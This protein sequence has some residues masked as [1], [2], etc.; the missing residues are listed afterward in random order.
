MET[1]LVC[2]LTANVLLGRDE[3]ITTFFYPNHFYICFTFLHS[4]YYF[5]HDF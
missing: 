1:S 2:V 5:Q 4:F 3:R